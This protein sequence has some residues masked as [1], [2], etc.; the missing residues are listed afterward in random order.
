[1]RYEFRQPNVSK[2]GRLRFNEGMVYGSECLE[3]SITNAAGDWRL[4]SF[5]QLPDRIEKGEN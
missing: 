3:Y 4:R 1:M 5:P 2:V